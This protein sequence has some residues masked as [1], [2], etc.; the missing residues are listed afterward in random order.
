MLWFVVLQMILFALSFAENPTN[1]TCNPDD[2]MHD[3]WGRFVPDQTYNSG[4]CKM[5]IQPESW[6]NLKYKI[7]LEKANFVYLQMN[8]ISSEPI[9]VKSRP[10]VVQ[11]NLWIWTYKG[12][13]GARQY[14]NWPMEYS[15]WS[16]GLLD[17]H[18][19]GPITLNV[20]VKGNCSVDIGEKNTTAR[21][22][23]AFE[24]MVKSFRTKYYRVHFTKSYFCYKQRM[25]LNN[26]FYCICNFITCP[27]EA[28]G[29]K[30]CKLRWTYSK[31]KFMVVC[32]GKTLIYHRLWWIIPF[33]IGFVVYLYIPIFLFKLG[34]ILQ[35][36]MAK[37]KTFDKIKF[38][39]QSTSSI[40]GDPNG[41]IL[42]DK[43]IDTQ[44]IFENP[45]TICPIISSQFSCCFKRCP[46]CMSRLV[47]F[48]FSLMTMSI[49]FFK[50]LLHG[51][52]QYDFIIDSV[53]RGVPMDFLSVFAGYEDSK[54]NFMRS[55]GG[56]YVACGLYLSLLTMLLCYPKDI[57][58]FLE[59]GLPNN[60]N[61]STSPLNLDIIGKQR[62]GST[63]TF[64]PS[65]GYR[66][67]NDSMQNH[68]Y[69]ILNSKFW[70]HALKIQKDRWFG[71]LTSFFPT[72]KLYLVIFYIF[73]LPV[74]VLVCLLELIICIV[75]FGFPAIFLLHVL[76]RAFC[77]PVW[78]LFSACALVIRFVGV[79]FVLLQACVIF[80]V[81]YMF[82]V[83]FVDSFVF[84][85]RVIVFTYSGL[86]AYPAFSFSYVI[87]GFSII[88]Y[89]ADS[90]KSIG[91]VYRDL[92]ER[93]KTLCKKVQKENTKSKTKI[94]VFY[95]GYTGIPRELF[96]LVLQR[97]KPIRIQV[98]FSF[99][100]ILSLI[101][102]IYVSVML[103]ESFKASK[104]F[105][106]LTEVI[107]TL[108]VCFVPKLLKKICMFS[109]GKRDR[110]FEW[111]LEETIKD[112]RTMNCQRKIHRH[113]PDRCQVGEIENQEEFELLQNLL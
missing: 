78:K 49:I 54:N 21:L 38:S 33:I 27:I 47:R 77:L 80:F 112:F 113:Q 30:C 98:F 65:S 57:S 3:E 36:G 84:I 86:F 37:Y 10:C 11:P 63:S 20:T 81:M 91:K 106:S 61:L 67:I 83:V 43:D 85:S 48:L 24:A 59:H 50:L 14:L 42:E 82:T 92:F 89:V 53:K 108:F 1:L 102:I 18:T 96:Q 8:F 69:M 44:M 56:P 60:P 111:A 66:K 87:F 71:V 70:K 104:D 88:M 17:A 68:F 6:R 34:E 58:V 101:C 46:V 4:S 40:N 103:L 73:V 9:T 97:H 23:L 100:K 62:F 93:V 29:Y 13:G 110:E 2:I 5:I 26:V 94:W 19:H 90:V 16:L 64:L 51:M 7:I 45:V 107:S 95:K 79:L 52:F 76:L 25:A 41:A 99:L 75:Y 28:I 31:T 22:A 55:F 35:I 105:T 12:R 39:Y 74:Y 15:V 72:C 32:P 109:K